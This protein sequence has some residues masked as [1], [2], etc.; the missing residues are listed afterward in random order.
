MLSWTG[1]DSGVDFASSWN[2]AGSGGRCRA[3]GS[4]GADTWGA[5]Q[6]RSWTE[7]AETKEG[8]C[9]DQALA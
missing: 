6:S 4:G 3:V 5:R 8:T 7:P 9:E 1:A 2:G